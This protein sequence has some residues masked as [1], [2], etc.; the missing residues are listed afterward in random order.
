[1]DAGINP[2]P[3]RSFKRRLYEIRPPTPVWSIKSIAVLSLLTLVVA[4]L[5]IFPFG[6]RSWIVNVEWLLGIVAFTLFAMMSVGLY[7]GVK[8]RELEPPTAELQQVRFDDWTPDVSHLPDFSSAIDIGGDDAAG[9][10]GAIVGLLLSLVVLVVLVL[11][12]WILLQIGALVIFV[13]MT[14]IYWVL[15]LALRQVFT[16]AAD[17][18]GN[19][20]RSLMFATLYTVLYTGWLFALLFLIAA[21]R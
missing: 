1:M 15:H 5:A 2:P 7:R 13:V 17:C 6:N 3:R 8:L 21:I 12:A 16:H 9:C 19:L 18:H 10:L 14:A 20:A 11:G 4:A